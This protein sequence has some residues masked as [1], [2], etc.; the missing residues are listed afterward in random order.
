M[1]LVPSP[2]SAY[3]QEDIPFGFVSLDLGLNKEQKE[4]PPNA[5]LATVRLK[6]KK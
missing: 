1:Q 4:S 5:L 3:R 6:D 2:K